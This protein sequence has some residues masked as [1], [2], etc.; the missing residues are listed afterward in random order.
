MRPRLITLRQQLGMAHLDGAGFEI[1]GISSKSWAVWRSVSLTSGWCTMRTAAARAGPVRG[2]IRRV[3]SPPNSSVIFNPPPV[4]R[5]WRRRKPK[6]TLDR[7]GGGGR[8]ARFPTLAQARSARSRSAAS[9][10]SNA[11]RLAAMESRLV[12]AHRR[13]WLWIGPFKCC[14]SRTVALTKPRGT[15]RGCRQPANRGMAGAMTEPEAHG[16]GSGSPHRRRD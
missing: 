6:S 14:G 2:S 9:S 1:F 5:E 13:P 8:R 12:V 4:F 16:K 7:Q 11:L 15:V 10:A 3:L